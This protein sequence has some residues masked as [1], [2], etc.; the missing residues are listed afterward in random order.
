MYE[1]KFKMFRNL[2]IVVISVITLIAIIISSNKKK[3]EVINV[4]FSAQLTGRQA[5]LGVQERNGAQL[6]IEKA[7]N[8]G[9]INGHMLSLIVHDDLGIPQ[10]AQ[11]ADKELIREGVVAIIG[12]ATTAQTLAGIA[13][14]NKAKVIMMGPTVSTPKLSG[15]D[16]YFFRIHPSFEKS[17]Q[18][19]AKYIFE[20]KGIKHIAVIFDKDNLAYSQNY[21]DIFSDK[22]KAL[23]GEVTN[24]LDFSS[25]AQPDF[26]KFISEL[27]KSK[28]EGVLI[29]ASDMDTALIAQRARLMN[30]SNPMF[31][32]PWA[33][34]KTLID[35]GGQAVEGMII[36]QAY[37]LENDSENFVEFK[38]KYRARF[39]NDPSFG[40]A[41]SYE[42]TV[43]LIEA[44]KKSYG[45]NLSL[46][47]ALLEIHD[48]K[49]LTDNL[50]FDKF[51]DIQRNSYL[52]SIK[53]GKFIR[54][55]KLN[56]VESGGE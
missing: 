8:D 54:I 39:G 11:N 32:S 33:Q 23:G 2:C 7:N 56:T 21:S 16:D 4:G 50:S 29:V 25:V 34:T 42:S 20:I 43:V 55:A 47:D 6:A 28:A 9:G 40:A 52:S 12:H 31:S 37:D 45:T 26:S 48:F 44:I 13:E 10:E 22:F 5:E 51:G 1:S 53:N 14:A 35:K 24:L 46:K 36:E 41:Y 38:S 15:I 49:G 30:W 17:S 27:Q 18:N 19:F 3:N